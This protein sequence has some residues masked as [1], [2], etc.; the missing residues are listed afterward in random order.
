MSLEKAMQ[1]ERRG[2]GPADAADPV[3]VLSEK[4]KQ[5][6]R[7][8]KGLIPGHRHALQEKRQPCLPIPLL[9]NLIKQIII[10]A[11]VALEK[12]TQVQQRL[13]K[14]SIRA[15]QQGDKKTARPSARWWSSPVRRGGIFPADRDRA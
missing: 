13:T 3:T 7:G 5:P 15:E 9:A 1:F 10:Q 8:L 11:A 12:Q 4:L 14:R 2:S 6:G